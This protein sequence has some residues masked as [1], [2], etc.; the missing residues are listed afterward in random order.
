M[1]RIAT[2]HMRWGAPL[3]IFIILAVLFAMPRSRHAILGFFELGAPKLEENVYY[4][5]PM[6]PDVRLPQMGDCPICGMTLV[7]KIAAEEEEKPELVSVTTQQIQL[8]GVTIEPLEI[9]RLSKEIDTYGKIDYDETRLAVVS[10]WVGGRIDKLYVDFTGVTVNKGHPLVYLYSPDLISTGREFLLAM[11]NLRKVKRSENTEAIKSAEALVHSS[12]QRLLR[13]GLSG[14][15]IDTIAASGKVEDHILIYAPQ[16]GTV[17]EK[18]TYEGM[19]VK[20][21]DVLFRIADLSRVWLHADIYEDEIPFLY[22][23]RP[24]DFYECIMHPEVTS[25]SPGRCYKCGMDLIR[26]NKS[27]KVEITT[28]AFPEEVFV[29]TISF[30]D[31]FLDPETRTVRIRVNIENPEQKLKPDM[32]ARARI[33]LPVGEILAVPENGVIHS[34]KR[35]IV[36]V[37]EERGRFRPQPVRLGRMWL[38]DTAREEAELEKLVFERRAF[39]YHEVLAGLQEGDRVVTS[40]TFLL[41]SESQLQ[42]AL[43]KMIE[44][45]E[46]DVPV[47][48]HEKHEGAP[49]HHTHPSDS[50]AR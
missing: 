12:K 41:G 1:G 3:V 7:K 20:E 15:Q 33:K 18:R 19:Y 35:K 42:G 21:G 38:T 26:T 37:E 17:I 8:T 27:V 44:M 22:Q 2:R 40:G 28:R 13:W 50:T 36:L 32:Y 16:G 4:T 11:E 6:H 31:P 29:G 30:T 23:K 47:R 46:S 5:C 48:I 43:A 39:R 10:A 45:S 49:P 9:R 34:G 14:K 24:D 25:S